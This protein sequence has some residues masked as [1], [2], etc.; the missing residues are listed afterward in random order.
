[1]AH[2]FV[3]D[4]PG[5]DDQY[6][7]VRAQ[8]GDGTPDGMI[9]HVV[10]KLDPGLRIVSVWESEAHFSKFHCDHVAPAVAAMLAEDGLPVPSDGP[11]T[12]TF[13]AVEVWLGARD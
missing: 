2:A 11:V 10:L 3:E 1:V 12:E 8:L 9:A 5:T 4:I 6:R 13:D 7:R